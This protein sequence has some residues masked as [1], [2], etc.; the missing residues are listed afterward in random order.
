MQPPVEC[1]KGFVIHQIQRDYINRLGEI[2]IPPTFD[3]A[4]P[5]RNGLASVRQG[6][7]WGAINTDGALMIPIAYG[8]PLV[9][10]E[11]LASFGSSDGGNGHKRGIISL[12]GEIVLHP[13]YRSISHFSGG[14]ACVYTGELYGYINQE[15][16]EVIPP[17]F[18]GR[19]RLF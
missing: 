15:G 18:E 5:F 14:L 7:H 1:S 10:T 6:E 4:Y 16:R 19:P 9:F 8:G 17:F 11:G 12:S 13:R 2:V 3:R